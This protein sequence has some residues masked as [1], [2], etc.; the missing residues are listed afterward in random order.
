MEDKMN[1][2][3]RLKSWTI[4]EYYEKMKEYF[5]AKDTQEQPVIK[6]VS[7]NS[8]GWSYHY[9]IK[10]SLLSREKLVDIWWDY[11]PLM[12]K[13]FNT[14]EELSNQ[15][16]VDYNNLHGFILR[17]LLRKDEVIYQPFSI[18]GD[19]NKFINHYKFN[20]NKE[21][22]FG[23]RMDPF[24]YIGTLFTRKTYDGTEV[25]DDKSP[26]YRDNNNY[27][28]FYLELTPEEFLKEDKEY[29]DNH[30]SYKDDIIDFNI[31]SITKE[32]EEFFKAN[33]KY[34]F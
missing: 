31:D 33:T 34:N 25:I 4:D 1:Q 9:W 7:V 8:F 14:K 2:I 13:Y 29:R 19:V 15:L 10:P 16:T 18:E 20:Q 22:M 17:W 21:Y 30:S 28:L 23:R 26:E 27:R 12:T 11:E 32:T 3:N 6:I 24:T 5:S